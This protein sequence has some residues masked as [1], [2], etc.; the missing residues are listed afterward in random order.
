MVPVIRHRGSRVS[1]F[2]FQYAP[3]QPQH[4]DARAGRARSPRAAATEAA[5]GGAG[6]ATREERA[7]NDAERGAQRAGCRVRRDRE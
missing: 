4:A 3:P 5:A 6:E 7:C 2:I 1:Y